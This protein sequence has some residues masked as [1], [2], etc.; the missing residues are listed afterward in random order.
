MTT[1]ASAAAKTVALVESPTQL[2]NAVEWAHS[3][4]RAP[5]EVTAVVLAPRDERTRLQLRTMAAVARDVGLG[6]HWH[7]PRLGGAAIARTVR[8]LAGELAGVDRLVVG[9]PFSGVMQVLL[10]IA[11]AEEVVVV[12][13]GTAT[14]EFAR[15]W[16]TGE[17]L[18]RWHAVATESQRRRIRTLARDQ[19]A[20]SIRRRVAPGSGCRLSLYSCLPVDLPRVPVAR[21]DFAWTRGHYPV[22]RLLPGVDLVGTS[23]VETGVVD[24]DAYLRGVASL[25]AEHGVTRYFA[26]RKESADKLFRIT[27]L[28]VQVVRPQLPLEIVARVGP[29]ARTVLSF[30][31]TVVHT[32]PLVLA[33]A[34]VDLVVCA[35]SDDW[36]TAGTS[37]RAEEFLGT[38]TTTARD[39]H[40]LAAIAC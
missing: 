16:V 37:A 29:V 8:S 4:G 9:D 14:L 27:Q 3:S 35:I 23:L 15:Q 13:D 32:L 6:V 7:E 2:L 21:N 39:R 31:S 22:P 26:H 34:G 5:A 36:Y 38:V 24:A 33:D 12:D 1:T 11:R 20:D 19:I 17:H 40:H 10:N 25:V 30:P 28:G 18:S